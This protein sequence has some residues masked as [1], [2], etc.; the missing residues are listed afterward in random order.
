MREI[1]GQVILERAVTY[2]PGLV[3]LNERLYT[4]LLRTLLILA[5]VQKKKAAK[6]MEDVAKQSAMR[7]AD[8]ALR[9]ACEA[10]DA[11]SEARDSATDLIVVAENAEFEKVYKMKMK[12]KKKVSRTP[13]LVSCD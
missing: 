11:A 8:S 3:K 7:A 2:G 12:K 6:K 13:R 10:L 4:A 9:A 5:R 1:A